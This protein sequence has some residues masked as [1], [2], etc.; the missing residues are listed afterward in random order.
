[1]KEEIIMIIEI[2]TIIIDKMKDTIEDIARTIEGTTVLTGIGLVEKIRLIGIEK[3]TKDV[4]DLSVGKVTKGIIIGI[5]AQIEIETSIEAT[6]DPIV[7]IIETEEIIASIEIIDGLVE[8]VVTIETIDFLVETDKTI[9]MKETIEI[10]HGIGNLVVHIDEM[11]GEIEIIVETLETERIETTRGTPEIGEITKTEETLEILVDLERE[12]ALVALG[13]RIVRTIKIETKI[14]A[15]IL[16][17][18]N[19]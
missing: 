10:I 12:A 11:I 4:K 3:E 15:E 9:D 14:N 5:E 8:I 17:R 19:K 1:M 16:E 18:E 13:R 2:I 6:Q 7:E